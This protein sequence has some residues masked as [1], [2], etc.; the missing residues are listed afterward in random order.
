M[1]KVDKT[2]RSRTNKGYIPRT[3]RD[4]ARR[5][6]CEACGRRYGVWTETTQYS[7]VVLRQAI[8][9]VFPRRWLENFKLSPN[10]AVNLVS[11]CSNSCHPR[12]IKAENALFSGDALTYVTELRR[13]NWP[14]EVVRKAAE[15]YRLMEIVSLLDREGKML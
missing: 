2:V 12:K 14:K 4:Q 1:P 3:L 13:L 6:R 10:V 9:H 11:I 5:D 15:Y 7:R 8:D